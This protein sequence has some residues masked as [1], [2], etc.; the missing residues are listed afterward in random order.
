MPNGQ[1][2]EAE[3]TRSK[4]QSKSMHGEKQ[5]FVEWKG[6]SCLGGCWNGIHRRRENEVGGHMEVEGT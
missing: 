3:R 5:I 6:D 2:R 4:E 1:T